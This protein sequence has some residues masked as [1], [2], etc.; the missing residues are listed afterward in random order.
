MAKPLSGFPLEEANALLVAVP[1][2]VLEE[3]ESPREKASGEVQRHWEACIA[4]VAALSHLG[5]ESRLSWVRSATH[6]LWC[7]LVVGNVRYR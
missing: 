6:G 5:I 2:E 7:P 3:S 4:G 1:H